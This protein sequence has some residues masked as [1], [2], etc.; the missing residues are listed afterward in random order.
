MCI[1]ATIINYR[2][3]F[4]YININIFSTEAG[5]LYISQSMPIYKTPV[6][7][8]K[9]IGI[10]CDLQYRFLAKATLLYINHYLLRNTH[11]KNICL[12]EKQKYEVNEAAL[13]TEHMKDMTDY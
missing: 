8:M 5:A 12:L 9:V 1:S 2:V 13:N 3:L 4:Q 6:D 11:T 10:S 7:Y